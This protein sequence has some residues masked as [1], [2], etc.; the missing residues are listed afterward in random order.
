MGSTLYQLS[1]GAG[2]QNQGTPW[3]QQYMHCQHGSSQLMRLLWADTVFTFW[4][5]LLD[6]IL[7]LMWSPTPSKQS[8][9]WLSCISRFLEPI[10]LWTDAR[11]AGGPSQSKSETGN[12]EIYGNM[13]KYVKSFFIYTVL[14]LQWLFVARCSKLFFGGWHWGPVSHAGGAWHGQFETR[15]C[16]EQRRERSCV[17]DLYHQCSSLILMY[18]DLSSFIIDPRRPECF[19]VFE[20]WAVVTWNNFLRH[21]TQPS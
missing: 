5:A 1:T 9:T 4:V 3:P 2:R 11:R 12:N 10:A 17:W 18:H 15:W 19:A 7:G 20:C 6:Y 8:R 13:V 16:L 21:L 14:L